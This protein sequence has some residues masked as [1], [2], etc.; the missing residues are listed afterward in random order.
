MTDLTL[1]PIIPDQVLE[2]TL[3]EWGMPRVHARAFRQPNRIGA[4]TARMMR[5]AATRFYADVTLSGSADASER[6]EA[7]ERIDRCR[8]VWAAMNMKDPDQSVHGYLGLS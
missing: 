6:A 2:D 3:V 7:K 1:F 8:E 5:E 4:Q